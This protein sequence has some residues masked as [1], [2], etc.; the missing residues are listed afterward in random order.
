MHIKNHSIGG[1]C[2]NKLKIPKLV[3]D[4]LSLMITGFPNKISHLTH[5]TSPKI[6]MFSS[7][8]KVTTFL[9]EIVTF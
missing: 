9:K 4:I 7:L 6:I 2:V 1:F 5:I 8:L 3:F